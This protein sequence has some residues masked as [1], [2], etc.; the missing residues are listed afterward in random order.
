MCLGLAGLDADAVTVNLKQLALLGQ[1]LA[2]RGIDIGKHA[3]N[4]AAS[5]EIC[6]LC[7]LL[8]SESLTILADS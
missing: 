2:D 7:H 5:R 8:T 4:Y 6:E 3:R 1:A